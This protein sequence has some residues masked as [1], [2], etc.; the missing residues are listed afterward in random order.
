MDSFFDQQGARKIL[1]AIARTR[2]RD[3][4]WNQELTSPSPVG[5]PKSVD[6]FWGPPDMMSSSEGERGSWKSRHSKGGCL[7]FML[8]ISSKCGQGEG[9]KKSQKIAN[10]INVCSLAMLSKSV[11]LRLCPVASCEAPFLSRAL[12]SPPHS[13]T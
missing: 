3:S 6:R 1:Y 8:Q 10:V 13:P 11:F 5:G 9:V 12:P 4:S 7:N 2:P